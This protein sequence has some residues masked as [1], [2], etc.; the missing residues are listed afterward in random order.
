[1][2]RAILEL[3]SKL[4]ITVYV[5]ITEMLKGKKQLE[6]SL[7]TIASKLGTSER[8]VSRVL[9]KLVKCNHIERVDRGIYRKCKQ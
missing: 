4:E 5:E 2:N 6:L 8:T 1:M 7:S 9:E 3:S